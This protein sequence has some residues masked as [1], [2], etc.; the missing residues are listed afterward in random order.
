MIRRPTLTALLSLLLLLP[1]KAQGIGESVAGDGD[2]ATARLAAETVD[3]GEETTLV[4]EVFGGCSADAELATLPRIEGLEFRTLEGP[5]FSVR[6]ASTG[7]GGDEYIATYRIGVRPVEV[8][9]YDIRELTVV[10]QSDIVLPTNPVF[11]RAVQ[12]DGAIDPIALQ[13]RPDR[14]EVYARQPF[15]IRLQLE[16]DNRLSNVLT[17]N[18]TRFILPWWDSIVAV[19]GP[20]NPRNQRR[21]VIEG[22]SRSVLLRRHRRKVERGG[23]YFELMSGEITVLAPEA[24]EL[25]LDD[26]RFRWEM[27]TAG[28]SAAPGGTGTVQVAR[29][30]DTAV[31]VLPIPTAGRPAGFVDAV[32]QFEVE[33]DVD[34]T[35]VAVG[36]TLRIELTVREKKLLSSNIPF[37]RFKDLDRIE[38]FRVFDQSSR[39]DAGARIYTFDVS[40]IRADVEAVPAFELCWFDPDQEAFRS[41]RTD[42]I[43]I[44][45]TP[46]PDGRELLE[47]EESDSR[48]QVEPMLPVLL[49]GALAVGVLLGMS[50]RRRTA[51]FASERAG[52]TAR[53]DALDTFRR[54]FARAEPD[55]HGQHARVFSRYL[56]SLLDEM[57]GRCSG[58]EVAGLLRARGVADDLAAEVAAWF[59]AVERHLYGNDPAP[60]PG[61]GEL[62]ALVRRLDRDLPGT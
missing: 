47:P 48:R 53:P 11:L 21:F 19:S 4:I 22:A 8:G 59:E 14:S 6:S 23:L 34:P 56:A 29:A 33:V 46:H 38:G 30:G 28:V 44:E 62:E 20:G 35:A 3:V 50:I 1:G 36:E 18:S 12:D 10:C 9:E 27:P 52:R 61:S 17:A 49:L 54:E 40:P 45:V 15:T 57:P 7:E 31:K 37:A 60:A 24:G 42:P 51:P 58:P 2:Y 55:D 13:V 25:S 26:S 16:V 5:V 32:G 41:E 43:P 39:R